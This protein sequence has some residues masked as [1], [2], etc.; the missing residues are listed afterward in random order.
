M[1]RIILIAALAAATA[2]ARDYTA[3]GIT[4]S[5][6]FAIATAPGAPVGGGYMTIRNDGA[7]DVLLSAAVPEE[8]AG[9]VQLHA[10]TTEDGVM[11]MSEVE[12]GIPLPSGETVTLEP[13]GLHVML[14]GLAAPLAEGDEMPATLTFRDTGTLDVVFE[15]EARGAGA[16][17]DHGGMDHGD[18]GHGEAN[19]DAAS[20]D[21]S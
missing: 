1:K 21:D 11:R 5:T 18:A 7:D 2:H 12:G 17:T 9:M 8:I 6:P 19:I 16:G 3:G 4:V 15:V 10:M 13:G 20:G 14:M